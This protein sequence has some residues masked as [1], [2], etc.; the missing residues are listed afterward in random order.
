MQVKKG[1]VGNPPYWGWRGV[2]PIQRVDCEEV[3]SFHSFG[4][5]RGSL[6]LFILKRYFQLRPIGDHFAVFDLHI[7]LDDLG[8]P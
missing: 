2:S 3:L 4:K 8:N 1:R 6:F 5:K 7:H